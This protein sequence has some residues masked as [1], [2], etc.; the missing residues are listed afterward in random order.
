MGTAAF[1]FRILLTCRLFL[2]V[3]ISIWIIVE[4]VVRETASIAITSWH[5]EDGDC[6]CVCLSGYCKDPTTYE[7]LRILQNGP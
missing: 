4:K 3:Q 2:R 7:V 6:V 1:L 5:D